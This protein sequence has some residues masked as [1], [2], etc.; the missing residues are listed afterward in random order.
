MLPFTSPSARFVF[1]AALLAALLSPAAARAEHR[2]TRLTD[3]RLVKTFTFNEPENHED[4]PMHWERLVEDGFPHFAE[5]G[6][7][8]LSGRS[9]APSFRLQARGANIAFTYQHRD[10][11]AKP[12][13]DYEIQ[14]WVRT[15]GLEHARAYLSAFYTD[16]YGHKLAGSEQFT[17][18]VADGPGDDD[19][20]RRVSLR[21]TGEYPSARVI[22]LTLWLTQE[23]I[24]SRGPV[25]P[26]QIDLKDV[27]ASAWFDDIEVRRLPRVKITTADEAPLFSLGKPA[28]ID[29]SVTDPD[30]FNVDAQLT[31]VDAEGNE[32]DRRPIPIQIMPGEPPTQVVLKGLDVGIYRSTLQITSGGEP[33]GRDTFAFAVLSDPP[34]EA[35]ASG[36]RFGLVLDEAPRGQWLGHRAVIQR[37]NIGSVKIPVRG[38]DW[39]VPA[40]T[41]LDDSFDS[42]LGWLARSHVSVVA[43][44]RPPSFLA[45]PRERRVIRPLIDSLSE[46]RDE[47]LPYVSYLLSRYADMVTAWQIG[48]DEDRSMVWD[49][50]LV[51]LI[52]RL[53]E[54]FRAFLFDPRLATPWSIEHELRP[55][56]LVSDCISVR[57]PAEIAPADIADYWA[58]LPPGNAE[59]FWA[60]VETLPAD[61]HSPVQRAADLMERFLALLRLNIDTIFV[62]QP[63][64]WTAGR[65]RP[66]PRQ[67][68]L[69]L[70][71]ASTLLADKTW[72][73]TV[74]L[75]MNAQADVFDRDGTGVLVVRDRSGDGRPRTLLTHFGD[76]I[77]VR[78]M[79]GRRMN[80][81]TEDGQGAIP[82]SA[83]PIFVIGVP[84]ELMM[85]RARLRLD[86]NRIDTA[87]GIQ[88]R[89][90]EF[91]NTTRYPIAGVIQL[92]VPRF[93]EVKPIYFPFSLQSGEKLRQEIRIR[94]PTNESAGEK[95][96]LAHVALH[97]GWRAAFD[98]PIPVTLAMSDV[99]VT[100]FAI[101]QPDRIV[102]R[103]MITNR[104]NGPI[105]FQGTVIAPGRPRLNRLIPEIQPGQTLAKEYAFPAPES[106]VGQSIRVGLRQIR[107]DR[108]YSESIFVP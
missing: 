87:P 89:V 19:G 22:G 27:Q 9:S 98:V 105:S 3:Q 29:V 49:D 45:T 83:E 71:A 4:I 17:A 82:V 63:W 64:G 36:R 67:E 38:D 99:D 1:C 14:A 18:L 44:L 43:E 39:T 75:D 55:D 53:K 68:L 85:L 7:D 52:P 48:S 60:Y 32:I 11:P 100:T 2:S 74:L 102:I 76:D 5:G 56:R 91:E 42:L 101:T 66:E 57:I 59:K 47:W 35:G 80:I 54:E 28:V 21:L 97:T 77:S 88:T 40:A 107:G 73:G 26:R 78:D 69:V 86:N 84:T 23:A 37:L 41:T 51:K 72:V 106:L 34:L 30:G 50:R 79:Y 15:E 16:R 33:L 95:Q 65:S 31:T 94:V 108:Q 103:Q 46:P 81:T 96:F 62:R 93:W 8:E 70:Q 13:S 20:W 104:T 6:F 12:G 61:Q 90:V 25:S 58:S 10:I 92:S 24:W